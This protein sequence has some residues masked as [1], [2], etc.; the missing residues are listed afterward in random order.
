MSGEGPSFAAMLAVMAAVA[1]ACRIAGYLAM[2]LVRPTARIEAA[3]RATPIA[4]M[5]GITALALQ[6]GGP[7]EWGA[8][9]AI[10]GAFAILRNDVTA[11]MIGVAAVAALRWAGL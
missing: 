6:S 11:A 7:A 8:T 1:L 5:A 9:G 3:L 2:G 4:V 10:L